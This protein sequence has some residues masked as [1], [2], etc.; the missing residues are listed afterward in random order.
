MRANSG[1]YLCPKSLV[2]PTA[3]A[4]LLVGCVAHGE[5]VSGGIEYKRYLYD[6]QKGLFSKELELFVLDGAG[7][8]LGSTLL[9]DQA[10]F[11]FSAIQPSNDVQIF[12]RRTQPCAKQGA[13]KCWILWPLA[14]PRRKASPYDAF[15][16]KTIDD[17]G[18]LI[19]D[20]IAR[21]LRAR[22]FEQIHENLERA[23]LIVS[24]A[25]PEASLAGRKWISLL[26]NAYDQA[27]TKARE[28]DAV[29]AELV[30]LQRKWLKERLDASVKLY[31]GAVCSWPAGA[32]ALAVALSDWS[33]FALRSYTTLDDWPDRSL[34][35]Q[36]K[37]PLTPKEHSKAFASDLQLVHSALRRCA[38]TAKRADGA[39]AA[40]WASIDAD[41][42]VLAQVSYEQVSLALVSRLISKLYAYRT[43]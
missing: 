9:S 12:W 24:G 8:E 19:V 18:T 20:A 27:K 15:T 17:L 37:R 14:H 33:E 5:I 36:D 25:Y 28:S 29:D 43:A 2:L 13:A 22:R 26:H 21:D 16:L 40:L 31:G 42:A 41:V 7:S 11:R 39:H 32:S 38:S 3:F 1:R 35:G 4:L 34:V 30:S 6:P 10:T 23:R